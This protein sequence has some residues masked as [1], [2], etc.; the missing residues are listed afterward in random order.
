[1][2]TQAQP[3]AEKANALIA[4]INKSTD[5]K[6]SAVKAEVTSQVDGLKKFVKDKLNENLQAIIDAK[7]AP[8][9]SERKT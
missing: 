5:E 6:T 8:S 9:F 3:L 7:K 2:S 1:M 4:Q